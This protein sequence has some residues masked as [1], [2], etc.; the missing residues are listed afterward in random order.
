MADKIPGTM[1]TD[2]LSDSSLQCKAKALILRSLAQI[3]IYSHRVCKKL[4]RSKQI[5]RTIISFQ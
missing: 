5:G 2:G 1:Q 4:L 3:V